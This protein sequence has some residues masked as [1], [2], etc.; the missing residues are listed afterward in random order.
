MVNF[1]GTLRVE[2][3]W[4]WL[5]HASAHVWVVWDLSGLLAS[6]SKSRVRVCIPNPQGCLGWWS[7]EHTSVIPPFLFGKSAFVGVSV[8]LWSRWGISLTDFCHKTLVNHFLKNKYYNVLFILRCG[9]GCT[10]ATWKS[11]D[12]LAE[13]TLSFYRADSGGPRQVTRLGRKPLCLLSQLTEF[14]PHVLPLF[15]HFRNKTKTGWEYIFKM[16]PEM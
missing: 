14:C 7:M 9:W 2:I 11:G 3:L 16:F 4:S 15:F 6:F 10:H 12:S 8:C 5:L 13:L 1:I